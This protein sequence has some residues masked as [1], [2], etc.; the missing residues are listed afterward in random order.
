MVGN[1]HPSVV[2]APLHACV[3]GGCT[4]LNLNCEDVHSEKTL[5]DIDSVHISPCLVLM[6]Q[7][8]VSSGCEA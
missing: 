6:K 5:Y 2:E 4:R 7:M 3:N 1:S 8:I